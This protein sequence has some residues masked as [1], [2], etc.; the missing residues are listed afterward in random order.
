MRV[1]RA[2]S[3]ASRNPGECYDCAAI[4]ANQERSQYR[5]QRGAR[6]EK[7]GEVERLDSDVP[8][9]LLICCQVAVWA[10]VVLRPPLFSDI[11]LHFISFHHHFIEHTHSGLILLTMPGT[12]F[13]SEFTT[14]RIHAGSS[15]SCKS[16]TKKL[17]EPEL[18]DSRL[19]R[20]ETGHLAVPRTA[21][22]TLTS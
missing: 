17:E 4:V 22:C 2:S 15:I 6:Q 7:A 3:E 18:E 1:K 11:E 5:R 16:P 10:A 14:L 12:N 19:Q 13:F 20:H 9:R 8:Q 21:R